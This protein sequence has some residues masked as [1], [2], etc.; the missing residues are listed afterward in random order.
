M[1]DRA[2][3]KVTDRMLPGPMSEDPAATAR[4][5]LAPSTRNGCAP[6]LLSNR[7]RKT[8]PPIERRKI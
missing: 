7:T 5:M 2:P 3:S 6:K 1:I 4:A 8:L